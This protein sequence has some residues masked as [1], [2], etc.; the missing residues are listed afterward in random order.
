MFIKITCPY[1]KFETKK[2]VELY[3]IN[4]S[5]PIVYLC[6]PEDGGCDMYYAARFEILV[7]TKTYRLLRD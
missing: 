3:D 7:S 4:S 6:L 1:C 5:K 2:Q